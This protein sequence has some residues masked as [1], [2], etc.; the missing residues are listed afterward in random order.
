MV[1]ED[2]S[3]NIFKALDFLRDTAPLYAKAKAERIFLEEF[4][5][6]K[7]AMLMKAVEREYPSAAAQEREA[8]AHPEYL[9]L[10]DALRIATEEE[11][12]LRWRMT[13]AQAKCSVWQTL[14]ATKRIEMKVV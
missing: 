13:A 12:K 5:K 7:K 9:E 1:N 10:L 6:S 14:E 11:E 2:D 4:R 3:I 8:Y